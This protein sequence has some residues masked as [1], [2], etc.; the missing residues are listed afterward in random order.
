MNLEYGKLENALSAFSG[1]SAVS[2]DTD[3]TTDKI[4]IKLNDLTER[5][6]KLKAELE[7]VQQERLDLIIEQTGQEAYDIASQE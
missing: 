6:N 5:E 3:T 7:Q 2:A 1:V 4:Q